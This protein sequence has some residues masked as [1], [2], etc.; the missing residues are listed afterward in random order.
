MNKIEKLEL[1]LKLIKEHNL[2]AYEIG[3]NTKLSTFAVQKIINGETKNP[4]ETTLEEIL[5]F[6]EKAIIS[7]DIKPTKV[8]ETPTEYFKSGDMSSEYKKCLENSID[9]LRYINYLKSI[10]WKN[11]LQFEDKEF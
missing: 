4:N 1:C 7:T 5:L 8:E 2:T 9:Q 6:I 10:L 3:K 11:N